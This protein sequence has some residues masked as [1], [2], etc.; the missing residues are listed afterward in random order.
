MNYKADEFDRHQQ[1]KWVQYEKPWITPKLS[2]EPSREF[3]FDDIKH[4]RILSS[5]NCA[6]NKNGDTYLFFET[7]MPIAQREQRSDMVIT[8][9]SKPLFSDQ[10]ESTQCSSFVTNG[11]C[12]IAVQ[13]D[14]NVKPNDWL[15]NNLIG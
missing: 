6:V 12:P 7:G 1:M 11:L 13:P 14:P 2:Y 4:E 15:A 8:A 3:V 5:G 10:F 9:Y